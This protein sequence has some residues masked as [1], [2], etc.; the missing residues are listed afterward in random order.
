MAGVFS[1]AV[2]DAIT[3]IAEE[4]IREALERGE[5]DNLPGAGLP[6]D[7][8]DDVQVSPELRMAYTLLK[9]A[10]Y[11]AEAPNAR[12]PKTPVE[13]LRACLPDEEAEAYGGALRLEVLRKKAKVLTGLDGADAPA[14]AYHNQLARKINKR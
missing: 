8:A 13:N 3:F 12:D 14:S 1:G 4:R 9:N 11:L 7:L 2:M 5:F 6:L 10:G